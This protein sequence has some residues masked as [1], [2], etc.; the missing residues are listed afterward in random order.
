M[1]NTKKQSFLKKIISNSKGSKFETF[2]VVV[3]THKTTKMS[4]CCFKVSF[5]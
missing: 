5:N 4:M 3:E 1:R 2:F